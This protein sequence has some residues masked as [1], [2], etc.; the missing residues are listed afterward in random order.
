MFTGVLAL[1]DHIVRLIVEYPTVLTLIVTLIS[2]TLSIA[3]SMCVLLHVS[4]PTSYPS[5]IIQ[6]LHI[7]RQRSASA[8][9]LRADYTVQASHCNSAE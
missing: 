1:P 2:T 9:S 3:T 5:G 4:S 8:P 6:V 7:C